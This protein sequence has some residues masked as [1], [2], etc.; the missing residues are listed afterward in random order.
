MASVQQNREL[1]DKMGNL[2]S[3]AEQLNGQL[4]ELREEKTRG[5][6]EN[7]RLTIQV[8]SLEENHQKVVLE[9]Q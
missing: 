1:S 3:E 2:R 8:R 5:E 6:R 7:E 4:G 9:L